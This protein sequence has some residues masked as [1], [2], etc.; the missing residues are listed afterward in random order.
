MVGSDSILDDLFDIAHRSHPVQPIAVAQRRYAAPR[1]SLSSGPVTGSAMRLEQR[2]TAAQGE[3]H[4][5]RVARDGIG[6]GAQQT[7]LEHR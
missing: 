5:S 7:A 4:Q 1:I 6:I 2:L 3:P